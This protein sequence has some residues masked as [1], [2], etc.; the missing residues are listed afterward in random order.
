[1]GRFLKALCWDD[2]ETVISL[3][4]AAPSA[5]PFDL[6]FDIDGCSPDRIATYHLEDDERVLTDLQV[7]EYD[8]SFSALPAPLAPYLEACL[9]QVCVRGARVAWLGFEGSFDY[10]RLLT[11]S[12]ARMLYGVAAQGQPTVLMLDDDL[13]AGSAWPRILDSY[14]SKLKG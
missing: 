7:I 6:A 10:D 9:E 13:R 2:D 1:M 11:D 4:A 8:L 5:E 3:F 14:R 12:V